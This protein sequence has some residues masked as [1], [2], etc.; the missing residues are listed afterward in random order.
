MIGARTWRHAITGGDTKAALFGVNIWD[1][2][3]WEE[4]GKTAK[5]RDP[6]YRQKYA[7]PVYR[8]LVNGQEREFAA[9]EFSNGIWGFFLPKD[10]SWFFRGE[11]TAP[12]FLFRKGKGGK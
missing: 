1:Y 4:T 2:Y 6:L 5:V 11:A 9:G 7:F 12:G 3:P 10:K 8:A